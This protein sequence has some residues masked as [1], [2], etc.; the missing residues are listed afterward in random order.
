M[1]QS[2]GMGSELRLSDR[3][4]LAEVIDTDWLFTYLNI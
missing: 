3:S 2:D 4:I 1:M